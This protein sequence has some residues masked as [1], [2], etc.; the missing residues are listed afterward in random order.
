MKIAENI[1]IYSE[2]ATGQIIFE[3]E[4]EKLLLSQ[5]FDISQIYWGEHGGYFVHVKEDFI[6]LDRFVL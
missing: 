4:Q 3:D 6:P 2:D 1:R 5:F